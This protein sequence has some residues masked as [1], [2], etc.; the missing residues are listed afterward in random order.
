MSIEQK[1]EF[2]LYKELYS[3]IIETFVILVIIRAVVDK[4]IDFYNITKASI[5][6]A[7]LVCIATYINKEFK[8]NVKQGLHYGVSTIVLNQFVP[9]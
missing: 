6:I 4:P 8:E 2:D 5:V 7:T 9:V 1:E 3:N